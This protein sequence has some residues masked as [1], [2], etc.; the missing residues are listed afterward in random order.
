[1]VILFY[2]PMIYKKSSRKRWVQFVFA[3]QQT[4]GAVTDFL[5]KILQSLPENKKT[6]IE[7]FLREIVSLGS[8]IKTGNKVIN[9]VATS[10]YQ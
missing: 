6:P 7:S 8:I 10:F 9:Q 3:K 5:W 2:Y 4:S 1:M